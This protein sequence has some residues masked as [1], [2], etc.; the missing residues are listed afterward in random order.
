MRQSRFNEEQIIGILRE[1]EA[2]AQTADVCRRHGISSA[3]FYKWKA[4]YGG[5][6]VSEAR[7]L[8]ALSDENAK[9]KKLLDNAM[10]KDLNSRIGDTRCGAAY[11]LPFRRCYG[12]ESCGRPDNHQ[13]EQFLQLEVVQRRTTRVNRPQSRGIVESFHRTLLDEHFQFEGRNTYLETIDE[14]QKILDEYF[15]TYNTRRP[16][17]GRGKK[18]GTPFT[19]FKAGLPIPEPRKKKSAPLKPTANSQ[20]KPYPR[21]ATFM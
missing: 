16:H 12:R 19:V 13:Y 1:Q 18:S 14:M 20:S 11:Y 6:D 17:Q 21:A 8:K 5:L 9:L 7:R 10:L 4:K 15:V 3:T 2:G